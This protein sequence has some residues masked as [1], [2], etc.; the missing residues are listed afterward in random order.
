MVSPYNYMDE[1]ITWTILNEVNV[2]KLQ[3]CSKQFTMI[4]MK[5]IHKWLFQKNLQRLHFIDPMNNF[6]D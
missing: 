2:L 3:A 6:T 1:E 5:Y 4:Q